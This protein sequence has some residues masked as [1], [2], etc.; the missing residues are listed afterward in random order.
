MKETPYNPDG[1][2]GWL[3][4]TPT[5]DEWPIGDENADELPPQPAAVTASANQYGIKL[6]DE[7]IDFIRNAELH[8]HLRSANG[9]FLDV[10]RSVLKAL[11][12]YL[13]R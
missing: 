11:D 8:K 6:P 4:E 10:A 5:H 1:S 3:A 13:V 12:G 2:S 9:D 7:F